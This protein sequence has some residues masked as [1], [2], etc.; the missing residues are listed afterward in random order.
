MNTHQK[1]NSNQTIFKE[2]LATAIDLKIYE[3]TNYFGTLKQFVNNLS[4]CYR[5]GLEFINLNIEEIIEIM[6]IWKEINKKDG[7]FFFF[8]K[9]YI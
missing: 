4:F 9:V 8:K 5:Y 3:K 1:L 6:R 7:M 2:A